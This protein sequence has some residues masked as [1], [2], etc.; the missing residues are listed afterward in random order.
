MYLKYYLAA[1]VAYTIWG[2]FSLPLRALQAYSS[3]D[4]LGYRIMFTLSLMI[5]TLLLFRRKTLKNS[6]DTYKK[7]KSSEKKH[8]LTI[9]FLSGLIFAVNWFV[10]IYV[11]NHVSVNATSL[12]Y[13]I[14]PIMTVVLAVFI[15]KEKLSQIQWIAVLICVVSCGMMSIGHFEE[16]MYSSVVALSYAFYPILQRRNHQLDRFVILTFQVLFAVILLL[17]F[18]P[19]HI[20][21]MEKTAVF[22]EIVTLIAI[23]FTIIPMYLTIYALKGLNSSVVG[24]FMYLNPIFTFLLAI[25]YFN[26]KLSFVQGLGFGL[27]LAGI[28]L[29][30]IKIIK[31][32]VFR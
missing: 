27:I 16:L 15:L 18:F 14:C 23:L 30:N 7:L 9:N 24:I 22:Y 20:T 3:F 12:A 29:F 25:F 2:F 17:P 6:W 1:I 31:E 4:I 28:I 19:Y 10:F 13:L 5:L 11:M 21:S 26:E 8:L 32:K